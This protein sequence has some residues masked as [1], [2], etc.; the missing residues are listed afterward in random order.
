MPGAF[1]HAQEA[2]KRIRRLRDRWLKTHGSDQCGKGCSWCCQQGV[3][4]LIVEGVDIAAIPARWE[5]R[6]QALLDDL[7][8]GRQL[9]RCI[10][11]ADHGGACTI[12]RS[13]PISCSTMFPTGP[14]APDLPPPPVIDAREPIW[15]AR[16]LDMKFC[17]RIGLEYPG[18]LFLPAAILVG[19]DILAGR[20]PHIEPEWQVMSDAKLAKLRGAA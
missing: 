1:G 13:R 11:L 12:Y 2:L 10:L 6:R 9:H 3:G 16:E 14:C 8:L 17:R 19:L 7:K 18:P 4:T 20:T 5:E 15:A